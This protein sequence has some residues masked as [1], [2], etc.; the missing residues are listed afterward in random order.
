MNLPNAITLMRA[1]LVP[2]VFWLMVSGHMAAAFVVFVF[3][4]VSDAIDG[5]LAERFGLQTE[6]GA[7]L[8]PIADKLLIVCVFIAMAVGGELP[9]WV[10]TAVVS[11][12][13]LIVTA[14]LVSWLMGRPVRIKPLAISKVNTTAQ[15]GLAASVLADVAFG[16][17]LG[18]LRLVL[19]WI[20]AV[21]TIA[22]LLAY[23]RAWARH[24][25]AYANGAGALNGSAH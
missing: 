3:A 6:L 13:V 21:L 12:D 24:M 18:G 17:G 10:V 20:T 4:G 14:V 5:F 1:L 8:D 9:V 2:V 23:I 25:A 22:S 19:T 16:L 7:Y 11:R 15:I